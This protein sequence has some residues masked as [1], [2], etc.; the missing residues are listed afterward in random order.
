LSIEASHYAPEV[1]GHKQEC[2]DTTLNELAVIP[3]QHLVV[4]KGWLYLGATGGLLVVLIFHIVWICVA[5]FPTK[6]KKKTA[7]VLQNRLI[8]L[9]R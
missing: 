9:V 2:S 4:P 7:T 5:D 6:N 1:Y 8:I 3:Q